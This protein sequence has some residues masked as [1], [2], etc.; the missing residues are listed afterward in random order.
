M[1]APHEITFFVTVNS[2]LSASSGEL[3]FAVEL[4]RKDYISQLQTFPKRELA[5]ARARSVAR[6]LSALLEAGIELLD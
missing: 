2:F 6:K 5:E 1:T 4:R 3:L